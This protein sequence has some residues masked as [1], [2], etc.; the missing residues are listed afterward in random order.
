M[1]ILTR[2]HCTEHSF[3]C[4]QEITYSFFLD[5]GLASFFISVVT[6]LSNNSDI[7]GKMLILRGILSML[8]KYY[9]CLCLTTVLDAV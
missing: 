6:L 4:L 5:F 7:I 8:S 1:D 2:R 3:L 9:H